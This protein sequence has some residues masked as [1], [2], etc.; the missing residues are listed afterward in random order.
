MLSSARFYMCARCRSQAFICRR[1]DR[2]QIYCTDQCAAA[3]RHQ[4]QRE[5]CQRYN[6][7]R[8]ARTLNAERQRRYRLR[9]RTQTS[10]RVTDQGSR[11]GPAPASSSTS[12]EQRAAQLLSS[13]A[14]T[15]GIIFCHRCACECAAGVR[16]GFLKFGHRRQV[17]VKPPP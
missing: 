4:S 7:T 17:V 12:T 8:R 6:K 10:Q 15:A 1:C 5:A 16:L 2:G 11:I 3:S 9:Q 13:A 14:T